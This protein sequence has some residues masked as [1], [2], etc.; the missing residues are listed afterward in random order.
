MTSK[1]DSVTAIQVSDSDTSTDIEDN[2]T[3]G[4]RSLLE[5]ASSSED[6]DTCDTDEMK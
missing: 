1:T 3:I 2:D 5:I 6:S 4:W